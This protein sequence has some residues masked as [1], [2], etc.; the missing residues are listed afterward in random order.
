MTIA[1]FLAEWIR[2]RQIAERIINDMNKRAKRQLQS[3]SLWR[4]ING[5][6]KMLEDDHRSASIYARKLIP[7][8][9]EPINP[10]NE[11]DRVVYKE[12]VGT[13]LASGVEIV[14]VKLE[15]GRVIRRQ[16]TLFDDRT[17]K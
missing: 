5:S 13:V 11:G 12:K 3:H 9:A 10:F 14:R 6:E 4:A 2:N 8:E 15:D 16:W 7:L 1:H 17:D